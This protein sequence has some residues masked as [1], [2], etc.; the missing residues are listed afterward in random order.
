MKTY[1]FSAI[2]QG[3]GG[4]G[5]YVIV[6]F[7]VEHA[8][9]MKRVPVHAT[10]DGVPYRGTLVRMGM[11]DHILIVLKDIRRAIGKEIGDAVNIVVWEDTDERTVDIPPD[12]LTALAAAPDA[13]ARFEKLAYTH[14]REYVLHIND[15][16]KP[17][18]RLRRIEKTIALL[19]AS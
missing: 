3:A 5:A 11:P 13:K 15:A 10:I 4:G 14:R 19:R 12:L 16:K 18:T 8:F 9:G 2:I 17:E 7:D 6:P 1:R